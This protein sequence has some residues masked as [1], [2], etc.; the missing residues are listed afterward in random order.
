MVKLVK[1]KD[2]EK[3][4]KAAREILK[5]ILPGK[6]KTKGKPVQRYSFQG[7]KIKKKKKDFRAKYVMR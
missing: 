7:K 4:L 6:Y 2:M 5:F 3:I 1:T